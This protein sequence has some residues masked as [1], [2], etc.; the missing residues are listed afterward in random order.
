M[1]VTALL[2]RGEGII[3]SHSKPVI[4]LRIH[5]EVSFPWRVKGALSRYYTITLAA[6]LDHYFKVSTDALA[7]LSFLKTVVLRWHYKLLYAIK[8]DEDGNGLKLD[9]NALKNYQQNCYCWFCRSI[10]FHD[11]RQKAVILAELNQKQQKSRWQCS[12]NQCHHREHEEQQ[13]FPSAVPVS[14]QMLF[15]PRFL[16]YLVLYFKLSTF[17][18]GFVCFP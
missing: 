17:L 10:C 18:L 8:D 11:N 9:G 7:V 13:L 4:G 15:L 14:N 16:A 6:K 3:V 12:F 2:L 5:P 1:H